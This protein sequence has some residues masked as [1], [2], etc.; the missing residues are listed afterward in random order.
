MTA[1][2]LK[3]FSFFDKSTN[4]KAVEETSTT[5]EIPILTACV[6]FAPT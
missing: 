1:H 3:K 6:T 4:P 5:F 2:F